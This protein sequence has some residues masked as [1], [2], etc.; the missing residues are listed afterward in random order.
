MQ[1]TNKNN[2]NN[3]WLRATVGMD[4]LLHETTTLLSASSIFAPLEF[5]LVLQMIYPGSLSFPTF[6][7]IFK[8][9][10]SLFR[11]SN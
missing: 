1:I 10:L 8:L 9:F 4:L 3:L 5:S 6:Y 7:R 11:I 2:L